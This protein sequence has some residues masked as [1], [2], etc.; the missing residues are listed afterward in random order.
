M[1]N[2]IIVSAKIKK[3]IQNAKYED[4]NEWA[5]NLSDYRN[6]NWIILRR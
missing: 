5:K 1:F 2:C 6:I 4:G 3:I